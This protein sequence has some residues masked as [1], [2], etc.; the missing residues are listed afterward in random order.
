MKSAEVYRI[1]Y[2]KIPPLQTPSLS[3]P[4]ILALL[5]CQDTCKDMV[6]KSPRSLMYISKNHVLRLT[7]SYTNTHIVDNNQTNKTH[8]FK[9]K[10]CTNKYPFEVHLTAGLSDSLN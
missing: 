1:L 3:T 8:D 10:I 5:N 4:S 2:G 9:K 6:G 7:L